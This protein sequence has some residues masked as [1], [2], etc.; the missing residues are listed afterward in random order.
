MKGTP[1]IADHV[2]ASLHARLDPRQQGLAEV[3][4]HVPRARVDQS[5]HA[6]ADMCEVADRDVEICH[7]S[8]ERRP[9]IAIFD[10]QLGQ[11]DARLGCL[12]SAIH[13]PLLRQQ[14]LLL[15]QLRLRL[16]NRGFE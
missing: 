14:L 13:V 6:L 4:Q 5:E 9:D 3:P 2:H 11:P 10:I 8:F 12:Q 15:R 7:Q 16:L 1:G